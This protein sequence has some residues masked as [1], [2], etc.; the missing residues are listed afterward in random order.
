MTRKSLV[1]LNALCFHGCGWDKLC[2]MMQIGESGGDYSSNFKKFYLLDPGFRGASI[3]NAR[4]FCDSAMKP[5]NSLVIFKIEGDGRTASWTG[6][7][8]PGCCRRSCKSVRNLRNLAWTVT[9]Y[10]N[11]NQ[12]RTRQM[13]RHSLH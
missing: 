9:D 12:T 1:I 7:D 13:T 5:A 3:W 2:P 8:F 11:S 4:G 10:D 6:A